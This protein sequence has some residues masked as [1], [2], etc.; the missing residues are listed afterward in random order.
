MSWKERIVIERLG[1]MQRGSPTVERAFADEYMD[2]VVDEILSDKDS[3][4]RQ[5]HHQRMFGFGVFEVN[6]FEASAIDDVHDRRDD[7]GRP[8]GVRRN[9]VPMLFVFLPGDTV[10]DRAD[11][12]CNR[13]QS[14]DR[15]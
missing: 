8:F 2:S 11:L 3:V 9:N 12:L 15:T 1:A 5:S 14:V 10:A 7:M 4:V 6:K 13:G